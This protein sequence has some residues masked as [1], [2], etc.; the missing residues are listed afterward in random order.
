M[1]Y[2]QVMYKIKLLHDLTICHR[3]LYWRMVLEAV[4]IATY[5]KAHQ[6]LINSIRLLVWTW[7]CVEGQSWVKTHIKIKIIIIIYYD[8]LMTSYII[9]RLSVDCC[10]RMVCAP[11]WF[12]KQLTKFG[13]DTVICM[14]WVTLKLWLFYVLTSSHLFGGTVSISYFYVV[15]V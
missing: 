1:A 3:M 14:P 11:L 7:E 15:P 4:T 5:T 8:K 9:M 2:S 10:Y 6:N 13:R 12:S